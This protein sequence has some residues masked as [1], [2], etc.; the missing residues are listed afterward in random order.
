MRMLCRKTV[1][2][3]HRYA[4]G[5]LMTSWVQRHGD[6][7]AVKAREMVEQMRKKDDEDGANVWLRIIVAIGK[8]GDPRTG[9]R[10]R[11]SKSPPR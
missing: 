7:A 4:D 3:P 2:A 11:R 8:L 6:Y 9:A 10:H 1:N 5:V